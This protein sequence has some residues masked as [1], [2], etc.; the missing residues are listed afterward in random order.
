MAVAL[1]QLLD[2]IADSL[3]QSPLIDT[4]TVKNNQKFIR[5]GLIQTGQDGGGTLALYQK[6]VEANVEDDL[7]TIAQQIIGE[8]DIAVNEGTDETVSISIVGGGDV[9]GLN[10]TNLVFGE[11][12][13]L[14]VSQFIPLQQSSSIVNT[15]QAE[16]YLDTNIFELLPSGDVRQERIINFFNELNALLPPTAPEFDLND[17]GAV[18]REEGTNNWIGNV[19]YSKDNSIAY[20]QENTD[21]NIEEEN[22]YFHRLK[23]LPIGQINESRTIE[24]IYRTIAPYL[25]DIIEIQAPPQDDRPEYENQS[26][27]YLQFRNPNQGIIIRNT[28]QEFIEGLEPNN[29]TWLTS[30]YNGLLEIT[31]PVGGDGRDFILN[32]PGTGFTITMW[33]RFLDK[34]SSGTLFNF[35]NPTRNENPFGFRLE[36]FVLNKDD[37]YDDNSGNIFTFENYLN[38]TATYHKEVLKLFENTNTERF[39]RLQVREFGDFSTGTDFGLRDSH[40]GYPNVFKETANPPDLNKNENGNYFATDELRILNYT[41]IPYNPNEWY[42]ICATY[43]PNVIEHMNVDQNKEDPNW[44]LNHKDTDGNFTNFSNRGNKAKVEV[45]SRTDLLRARGFKV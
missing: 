34:I 26:S 25:T 38:N 18:D 21:G 3:I 7:E 8:Y 45:I 40:L 24:D 29:P 39:V 44:W 41:N 6:D 11:G 31:N 17:D 14:N 5:S 30:N 43:N 36:T 16:E 12:N 9:D 15:T 19:Q 4:T 23:N 42:F 35:G 2:R 37:T 33:V 22:A 28:N 10:I 20:A 13:P 32:N 1:E 27:G